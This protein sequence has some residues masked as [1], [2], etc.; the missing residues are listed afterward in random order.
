MT[1][2]MP[3]TRPE[4]LVAPMAGEVIDLAAVPD[5]A[6]ASKKM[7][8]G[9]AVRPT[10]NDVVSPVAGTVF[11]VAKTGH[12]IGLR[13][14]EG[15]EVLLH[16]GID[17]VEL[18]G[19]PFALTVAKGQE[20]AAGEPIGT[21]DLDQVVAA[22]KDTSAILVITNTKKRLGGLDVN[23][24]PSTLGAPAATAQVLPAPVKKAAATAAGA[25]AAAVGTAVAATTEPGAAPATEHA[26]NH[27]QLVD[28]TTLSG[29]DLLAYD[30]IDNVG[31]AD[32]IRSVIHCITRVRFYLK[33]EKL[34]NDDVVSNLDGVID[35]AKAG[36]QYQVV[37][38]PAVEDVFDAITKQ[39]PQVDSTVDVIDDRVKPTTLVGWLKYGFSELI[40]VITGSMI[41]IIGLLAAAGIL[42]G[43]L[44]LLLNFEVITDKSSTYAAINAMSDSVF[45]F[46]PIFVGFTAA[47]RLGS[48]PIVVAIIGGVLTHPVLTTEAAK[49]GTRK[50]AGM[51]L[52]ADFFGV[53]YHLASYSYSI[54]PI[55]VAAWLASKVEPWLKKVIP[56]TVRMIFVP[57]FEVFI[58]SAAILL[59]LGPIVTFLSAGLAAGIQGI[60][61]LNPTIAGGLIGGLYQSL[62]IF[63]LHWAVIPLVASDIASSGHSY[64]NAIISATMVAQ[65]G[66]VLAIFAKTKVAKIKELSGSAT[67]AAFSGITEPAMYGLNLKYGRA[68]ITASI[69]GAV[70]G[71][72]TGLFHVNMWGFTG[73]LIGFTSFINPKDGIDSSFWGYLIASAAA[74]VTSFVLTYMFGFTDADLDGE[75]TVKKVRLG[76]REPVAK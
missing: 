74:L 76:K 52:N 50:I 33:D 18:E 68:F 30:I 66:A 1:T 73:S 13:T 23:F 57:F 15:L 27:H 10:G 5:P 47:K 51:S 40:G 53:P 35:V 63:G 16:L 3:E 20:V 70:G 26:S 24:G 14:P 2:D 8:N 56:V 19:K 32:N 46:L 65:G 59:I 62:V 25:S 37:I 72:L 48:D 12:A 55:I 22:G 29:Y 61:D 67:L 9:F 4:E 71:L 28:R 64:L 11:M 36:G 69:G 54:F 49:E 45:Y 21:M 39:L 44:A 41:P 75:K 60:Y 31:G 6:F 43:V 7:G 38:G 42:K 17:T 58:V 34:A